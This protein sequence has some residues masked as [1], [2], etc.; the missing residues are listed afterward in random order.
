MQ[1]HNGCG[2]VWHWTGVVAVDNQEECEY[3]YCCSQCGMVADRDLVYRPNTTYEC[4]YCGEAFIGN[5]KHRDIYRCDE[6][7]L[8]SSRRPISGGNNNPV[9]VRL[10]Y[11]HHKKV[12]QAIRDAFPLIQ[13]IVQNAGEM[14][15]CRFRDIAAHA[16]T[17][18]Y[19]ICIP[20]MADPSLWNSEYCQT[21][22]LLHE[23]AHLKSQADHSNPAFWDE[24]RELH[25]LHHVPYS[26]Q[27]QIQEQFGWRP[28]RRPR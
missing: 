12:P 23:Y 7:L 24:N 6:H 20:G 8:H 21:T 28:R 11:M 5:D 22:N 2:H 15:Q 4:V 26:V 9:M 10:H 13:D 27:E 25:A 16:H 18:I 19:R 1:E 14:T 17:D 3:E